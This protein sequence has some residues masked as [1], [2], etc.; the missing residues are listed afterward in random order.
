[1]NPEPSFKEKKTPAFIASFYEKLGVPIRTNVGGN[2]VTAYIEGSEPGPAV[3]LRADFDA[4]PIQDEKRCALCFT[5]SRRH[6]RLRA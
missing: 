5:N 1:M 3:A 4:L 2:G 6:A